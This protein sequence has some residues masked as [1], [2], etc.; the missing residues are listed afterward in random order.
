MRRL[1]GKLLIH[2]SNI[3]K[4]PTYYKFLA[5]VFGVATIL[6]DQVTGFS[7][8]YRMVGVSLLLSPLLLPSM[9]YR[10]ERITDYLVKYGYNMIASDEELRER[11]L[12]LR[13]EGLEREDIEQFVK[14]HM[15]EFDQ[16]VLVRKL[17]KELKNNPPIHSHDR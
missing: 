3:R 1:I 7:L 6:A 5:I 10:S 2:T 16:E 8:E 17:Y 13:E 4:R 11:V 15:Q 9:L 12:R 14:L